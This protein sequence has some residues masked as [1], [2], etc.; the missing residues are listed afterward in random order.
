MNSFAYRVDPFSNLESILKN[1]LRCTEAMATSAGRKWP[2]ETE[3]AYLQNWPIP[4]IDEIFVPRVFFWAEERDMDDPKFN[5]FMPKDVSLIEAKNSN[6]KDLFS[7]FLYIALR[8]QKAIFNNK[9]FPDGRFPSQKAWYAVFPNNKPNDFVI[10]G[11]LF[12]VRRSGIWINLS[13]YLR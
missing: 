11:N 5:C 6:S 4:S 8:F 12:E 7:K 9:V 1:G 10:P 13:S 2:V 3:R